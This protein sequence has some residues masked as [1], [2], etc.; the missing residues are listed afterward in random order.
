MPGAGDAPALTTGLPPPGPPRQ[1]RPRAGA[2]TAGHELAPLAAALRAARRPV[3]LLGTGALAHAA[4]VRD[5]LAGSGI[6]A[7]HTYRARGIMPDSGAEAAGLVTGGTMEWPLLVASDLIIGLG[8]DPAEM[9]PV[10]WD[11]AAR[12]ILVSE[13]SAGA[14]DAG[15][16]S[17]A[18]PRWS[19]RSAPRSS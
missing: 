1:P 12:T 8:V 18:A 6:P 19:P 7:L 15:R 2:D 5:A 3:L 9:I 4:A 16:T 11:Y 17:P 14:A 13:T 10:A